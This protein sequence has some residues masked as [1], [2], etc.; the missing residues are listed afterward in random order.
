MYRFRPI[1]T[2]KVISLGF[3]YFFST[4]P[5]FPAPKVAL[6][7]SVVRIYMIVQHALG[8]GVAGSLISLAL[9]A[10][11]PAIVGGPPNAG[12]GLFSWQTKAREFNQE[13]KIITITTH[14][15]PWSHLARRLTGQGA[16]VSIGR[17]RHR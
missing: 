14:E 9:A 4:R 5:Q 11:K 10:E 3:V 16:G 8:A 2:Y 15:R 12:T 7:A 1:L 6:P 17:G 13:Y